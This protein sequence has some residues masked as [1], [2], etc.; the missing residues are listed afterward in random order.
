MQNT[1]STPKTDHPLV[2]ALVDDGIDLAL[3][4][5]EPYVLS[6]PIA[7]FRQHMHHVYY[8][9]PLS[10]QGHQALTLEVWEA[11]N[12]DWRMFVVTAED[13]QPDLLAPDVLANMIS[14]LR[15]YVLNGPDMLTALG[16]GAWAERVA[17][18]VQSHAQPRK[19]AAGTRDKGPAIVAY[20][21]AQGPT[22]QKIVIKAIP[23]NPTEINKAI[24]RLA[25]DGK[26]TRTPSDTDRR[27]YVLA[28]V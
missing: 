25:A 11:L 21:E 23:G 20:L 1:S 13:L 17:R 16:D 5:V 9:G 15:N 14:E 4:E 7:E 12:S 27:A 10:E 8:D 26:I 22:L 24:Q 18:P 3:G 28:L 19:A 6:F 2:G